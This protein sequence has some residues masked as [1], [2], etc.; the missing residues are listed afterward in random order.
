MLKILWL[1]FFWTVY[2]QCPAVRY[3]SGHGEGADDD[4]DD[5]D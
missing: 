2:T 3:F 1:C 5:D 4:D